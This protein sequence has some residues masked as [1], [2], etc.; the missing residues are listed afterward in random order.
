MLHGIIGKKVG[1]TQLF[2]DKGNVVPVTVI[3]VGAL[4]VTQVKKELTDG[5]SS[6]QLGLLRKNARKGI[7]SQEWLKSK[8]DYFEHIKELHLD[9]VSSY[10]QGQ[11][12]KLENTALQ[13][14]EKIK[15]TA[16]S[17]GLGFQGVVKRW[18]FAGGP[19][20]HGSDFH[21]IPGSLGNMRRQ[22]EVLKGKRLPGRAGA[23]QVTVSGL[24]IVRLDNESAAIFIK[25]AVPGKKGTL[26]VIKK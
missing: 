18:N 24:E 23:K 20:T 10:V 22:G 9:E 15:V 19:K 14:G 21:R 12:L 26:V 17:R 16:Q 2:D 4:F 7:F 25:G 1:M 13:V 6:V 3:D 11:P 5:Y 8:S